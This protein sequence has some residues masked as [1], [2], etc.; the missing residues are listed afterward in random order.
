MIFPVSEAFLISNKN[1]FTIVNPNKVRAI[2]LKVLFSR[3]IPTIRK[4]NAMT[5]HKIGNPVLII[6]VRMGVSSVEINK[7]CNINSEL[8]K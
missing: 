7:P 2:I 5:P 4:A 8:A 6:S 3:F 1:N